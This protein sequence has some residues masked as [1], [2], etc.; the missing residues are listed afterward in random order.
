MV[1]AMIDDQTSYIRALV[2]LCSTRLLM[3]IVASGDEGDAAEGER[4]AEM[5]AVTLERDGETYALA[6]TGLDSLQEWDKGARPV[7][8]HLDELAQSA[9]ELGAD[10]LLIDA[11]GP[12]SVVIAGEALQ[13][14]AEGYALMEFE[15]GEFNWVKYGEAESDE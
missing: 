1:L 8:C 3:P 12:F 6:F 9:A 5:A 4:Q 15:D 14:F 7:P 2:A 10:K 13:M 11:A